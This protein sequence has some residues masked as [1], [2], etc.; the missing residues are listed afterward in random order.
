MTPLTP[1]EERFA[2]AV[3]GLLFANGQT[4]EGMR[5]TVAGLGRACNATFRLVTG[6]GSLTLLSDRLPFGLTV[7]VT[8]TGVD[9]GRVRAAEGVAG[10]VM[11]GAATASQSLPAL[12]PIGR[13]P[14]VGLVRFAGM[15][16]AGA[17]ALAV[18]FGAA[19][20][21]TLALIAASAGLGGCLRRGAS[22]LSTNTFLQP[23][24]A[25]GLAGLVAGG[26]V[27][28]GFDGPHQL[29]AACPC[30]VLVPGPHLL[31]GAIDL[32]RARIAL[33]AARLCFAGI[34]VLAICAGLLLG[35][36]A[37]GTSLVAAGPAPHVPF[38]Y[39]MCA[40]GVAVAAYGSFFNMQWR[41]LPI[42]VAVGM[43]AHAL[44]W[45][46]LAHGASVQGG[47]LAACLLVGI[48][49]APVSTRLR[50]PFGA[51]AFVAVV[52]LMPGI[53]VFQAAAQALALIGSKPTDPVA[54]LLG[55]VTD[56]TTACLVLVA[57]TFGL[58]VPKLWLD[59]KV[60]T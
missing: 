58:I 43:L 42:P 14:L 28:F 39:D 27:A 22:H 26:S 19:D 59:H 4:T 8:P 31:N 3:A 24:L 13:L 55:L 52:S 23:F 34:I 38:A 53:F 56:G 9:M 41:T 44:R 10:R 35:L 11:A 17:A 33:G 32:V 29:I 51:L 37:T 1:D 57:M 5:I 2:A 46:L 12:D 49:M 30:M 60:E 45:K 21:L 7:I 48:V 6:W 15:A 25:A 40:A 16:A 20:L 36:A 47:A 50:L 54:I 18:I